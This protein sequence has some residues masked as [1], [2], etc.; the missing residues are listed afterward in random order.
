MQVLG[1]VGLA[2]ANI[3]AIL[4]QTILLTGLLS[5]QLKVTLIRDLSADLLKILI[6]S[7]VM[8]LA[9][10][11][12]QPLVETM[13]LTD[14]G[15]VAVL[16]LVVIPIAIAVYFAILW[17]IRFREMDQIRLLLQRFLRRNSKRA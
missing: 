16:V 7:V 13:P 5:K 2:L 12:C 4:G 14:K 11:A 15:E 1:V 17:L 6:S 9:I 8:V 10:F 3:L